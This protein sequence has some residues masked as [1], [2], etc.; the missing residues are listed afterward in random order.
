MLQGT[1]IT[2]VEA[3]GYGFIRPQGQSSGKGKDLFFHATGM[4]DRMA[5]ADL[6]VGQ[7]V[8]YELDTSEDRP[9][10]VRVEAV[11]D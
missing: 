9:R 10:A 4:T 3:K 6:E 5:F 8:T 2:I 11:H 1:V 7:P